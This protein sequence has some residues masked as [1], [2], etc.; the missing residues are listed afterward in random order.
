[1]GMLTPS[2]SCLVREAT[3]AGG[4]VIVYDKDDKIIWVSDGQRTLMPC[5][6]YADES[7]SSLFWKVF[8]A[9]LVGTKSAIPDPAS[10]LEATVAARR[11]SPNLDFVNIYPWGR[12]LVSHLRLEDGVSVQAR[13]SLK[14]AGIDK[15]FGSYDTGLGVMW[16]LRVQRHMQGMQSALD[17]L[18]IAVG[19][20][21]AEGRLVSSNASF[22]EMLCARD[23]LTLTSDECIRAVD[24]CDD[25]VL[26]QA[27]TH[28][29]SGAQPSTCIPI[30][31]GTGAPLI[32]AISAGNQLG[33]AVIVVSRFGEDH[34][35]IVTSL[36]Q[37]FNMSPAEAEIAAGIGNGQSVAEIAEARGVGEKTAYNQVRGIKSTLR[38]SQFVVD[39][40]ADI[41]GLVTK[42]AAITS[43]AGRKC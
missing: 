21:D 37:A 5:S 7:Y 22:R 12:M 17:S 11:T 23:A 27:V 35:S 39:D 31:R 42:V 36:R 41:A 28:I 43:P 15:Y 26:E 8:K 4:A 25:M 19:L 20:V 1:M 13:I 32:A 16:A 24:V 30:R 38:R 18:S 34:A 33:T 40:L 29:A 9:G 14:A 10:W 6:D 2:A 3:D